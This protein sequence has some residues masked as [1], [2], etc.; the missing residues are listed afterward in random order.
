MPSPHC[1]AV[2][3]PENRPRFVSTKNGGAGLPRPLMASS[4]SRVPRDDARM[5]LCGAGLAFSRSG[6]PCLFTG[7]RRNRSRVGG[8]NGGRENF[9]LRIEPIDI[10]LA[11]GLTIG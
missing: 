7:F 6:D 4:S 10:R 11:L 5:E 3:A 2:A 8:R 1:R 9:A